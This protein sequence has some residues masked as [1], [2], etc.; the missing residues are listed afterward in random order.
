MKIEKARA[1]LLSNYEV[2]ALLQERQAAQKQ[3]QEAQP[4]L[5]YPENLRTIQF[6][7]CA[8]CQT[9]T[10]YYHANAPHVVAVDR[11]P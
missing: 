5:E 10:I 1:A 2:F 9:T 11:I 8:K 6:E 4:D 3:M 7:A